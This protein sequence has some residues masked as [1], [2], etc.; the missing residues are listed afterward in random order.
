[1]DGLF[2]KVIQ[3]IRGLQTDSRAI[4]KD[5]YQSKDKGQQTD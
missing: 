5:N 4:Q 1:M 3:S 2:R